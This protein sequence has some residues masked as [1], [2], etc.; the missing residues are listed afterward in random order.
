MT[1]MEDS[2]T[3]A[4]VKVTERRTGIDPVTLARNWGIGLETAK[5]TVNATT[6]RGIQTVLHPTLSRQ[7]H[8]N[9]RQLRYRRLPVDCFTDTMFS[10]V[11]SRRMN[12]CAQVFSMPNGWCRAYP[13]RTKS[14]AHEAL[15]LLFQREG[16][17]NVMIMDGANEQVKGEF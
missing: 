15:S 8:T 14:Q 6:Q 7:F 10:T 13:M 9:D 11:V 5:R 12:K 4:S 3:I 2:I 17:P 16:V 1:A